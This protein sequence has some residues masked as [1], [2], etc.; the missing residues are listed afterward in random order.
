MSRGNKRQANACPDGAAAT[1][2]DDPRP[3]ICILDGSVERTGALVAAR[4][5]AEL[6][7]G[8]ARFL[9]VLPTE[10]GVRDV[11]LPEFERIERLPVAMLRK[12]TRSLV[13][14]GPMLLVGGWWLRRLLERQGCS[15][16]QVNDFY[17]AHAFFARML[18]F[19]GI[20]STWLRIDPRRFGFAG[21]VWLALASRFSD[22]LVVVSRTV[23]DQAPQWSEVALIYDPA[24]L[25]G[26]IGRPQGGR[27]VFLSNYIDGKGQDLAIR[28][29]HRLAQS[30]PDGALVFHGGTMGLDKNRAYLDRLKA[31]AAAGPGATRIRFEGPADG[32]AEA[33]A[34]ALAALNFSRSE[35]FSLTCQEA[36][37][38]G[39][40]IIA[41]R[42]GGPE[43]IIEDGRTGF[44]VELDN[45]EAMTERMMWL[46]D[47]PEEARIMGE[48]GQKRVADLFSPPS[49]ASAL[50]EIFNISYADR[51]NRQ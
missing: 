4:R 43:E 45:V 31:A 27:F 20:I 41:T 34:G 12:S 35:S 33:Y 25:L 30:R 10:S 15:R 6:L 48:A 11:D 1:L 39:L 32:P 3:W 13:T 42:S 24:P 9:L 49:A 23:R 29:F 38:A 18:G 40:P 22:R 37:A 46:L 47:H 5:E 21:R 26:N 8:D 28:A 14:Y 51:H 7:A 36:S 50:R 44:L 2:K 16:L 19:R 17:L